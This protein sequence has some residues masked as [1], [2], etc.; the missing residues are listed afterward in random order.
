MPTLDWDG[1]ELS[2][3]SALNLESSKFRDW[4]VVFFFLKLIILLV[5]S[6][7]A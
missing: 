2:T 1:L 3:G 7:F 4:F 6:I 5:H